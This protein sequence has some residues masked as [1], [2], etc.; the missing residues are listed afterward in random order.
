MIKFQVDIYL[1][2]HFFFSDAN[3]KL[4]DHNDDLLESFDQRPSPKRQLSS[5]VSKL[6]ADMFI[7]LVNQKPFYSNA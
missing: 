5:G 2:F 3:K 4:H 1:L 6:M 7:F